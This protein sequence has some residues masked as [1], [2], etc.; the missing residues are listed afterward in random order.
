MFKLF[1]TFLKIN[2]LT[3]SGPASIGL[4]KQLVVPSMVDEAKFSQILA[5]TSAIP[6]SDAI[7][8][9]FQIGYAVKGMLGAIIS[10]VGALIPTISL[11]G[12][13]YFSMNFIDQ[14]SLSKFFSGVNPALAVL[15][16]VTALGLMKSY[17]SVNCIILF[18]AIIMMYFKIPL[19]VM[20]LLSGILGVVLL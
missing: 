19:T 11:L 17:N 10:V 5:I 8:M 12:V 20:L 18:S 6:G 1:L 3:T 16:V 14:K 4:T 13:V 2:F 7:Q 9:A 15:L